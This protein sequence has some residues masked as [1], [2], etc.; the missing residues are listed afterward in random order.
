MPGSR[1]PTPWEAAAI[2]IAEDL[3]IGVDRVI[4]PWALTQSLD[5]LAQLEFGYRYIDLRAGWNG[6]AWCAH[7][8][9][10]GVPIADIL[11]DIATFMLEHPGE[12]VVVQTS[13]LDAASPTHPR[14]DELSA[15]GDEDTRRVHG[16]SGVGER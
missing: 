9:E 10:I 5:V 12:V 7:H 2:A 11:N 13:H 1:F 15:D 3:G 14:V 8:A 16:G 4:T 6:T